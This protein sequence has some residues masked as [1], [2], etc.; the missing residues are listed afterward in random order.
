MVVS[1]LNCKNGE[2]RRILLTG[3]VRKHIH[4]NK[5]ARTSKLAYAIAIMLQP[6]IRLNLSASAND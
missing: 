4:A 1:Y 2:D 5:V 6:E 3:S